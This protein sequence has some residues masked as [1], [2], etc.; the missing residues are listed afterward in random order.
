MT[1]FDRLRHLQCIFNST[2]L[3]E[4]SRCGLWRVLQCTAVH[5]KSIADRRI[6]FFFHW[7]DFMAADP[8]DHI[9]IPIL[10]PNNPPQTYLSADVDSFHHGNHGYGCGRLSPNNIH[11][12]GDYVAIQC[13]FHFSVN[14]HPLALFCGTFLF[15]F[16]VSTFLMLYECGARV[17]LGLLHSYLI[18]WFT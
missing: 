18:S 9:L 14:P 12:S 17:H 2:A 7:I 4:S 8:S 11:L 6:F 3:P 5:S 13:I 10:L 16:S 1:T 15:F